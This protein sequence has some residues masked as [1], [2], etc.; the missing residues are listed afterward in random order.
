MKLAMIVAAVVLFAAGPAAAA[1]ADEQITDLL[2][3]ARV[4]DGKDPLVP[5][6]DLQAV[7][8]SWTAE[9][10][11][12]AE[13]GDSRSDC[14]SHNPGLAGDVD[15]AL[16]GAWEGLAENVGFSRRT[17]ASAAQ[18]ADRLH[19]A[20]LD[21]AGHRRNLLGEFTGVGVGAAQ[22][23]DGTLWT[24]QVFARMPRPHTGAALA[25]DWNGDGHDTPGWFRD[26]QIDLVADVDDAE[27][28]VDF[29]Y[30]RRGDVPVAGDWNGD[31]RDTVAVI[32]DGVW[33]IRDEL[34]GG[35]ADHEFVY[36]RIAAG[37]YAL[38]GDWNG[39]GRDTPGVVR[40]G[41][42]LLRH[43]LAGGPA[44]IS[45]VYGR[46]RDGDRPLVGDWVGDGI[47][48]PAI[49]R[50]GV[51]HLR[52]ALVGGPADQTFTYGGADSRPLAGDWAD[53][54]RDA[55]AVALGDLWFSHDELD[56]GGTIRS[57]TR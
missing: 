5:D 30:G 53:V 28:R 24:T 40:D 46:V 33:L 13:A 36:G 21:S 34:A 54:G 6:E 35:R 2:N 37:D 4:G 50:D 32:R 20:F 8:Q 22:Q 31:G 43:E 45:F 11:A 19:A 18:L 23:P 15:A 51:W 17:G 49:V 44:D 42:W 38:A 29:T 55:A 56:A 16:G 47:D 10:K 52:E 26:G 1:P 12:C 48:T 3:D 7:A 14:L 39:D 27:A 41:Q 57:L 25:G 9:M